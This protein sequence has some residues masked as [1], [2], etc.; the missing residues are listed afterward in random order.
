MD[1]QKLKPAK[2]V[3]WDLDNVI[4][5]YD[6]AFHVACDEAAA[7]AAISLGFEDRGGGGDRSRP[8][9]PSEKWLEL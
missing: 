4:Y 1:K 9:F 3:I 6:A 2:L 7:R 5:P 8:K